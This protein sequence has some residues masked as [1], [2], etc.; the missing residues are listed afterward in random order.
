MCTAISICN[1]LL[2]NLCTDEPVTLPSIYRSRNCKGKAKIITK[3]WWRQVLVQLS[4]K[5]WIHVHRMYSVVHLGPRPFCQ[6]LRQNKKVKFNRLTNW[7]CWQINAR[8]RACFLPT[9]RKLGPS[10]LIYMLMS[11]CDVTGSLQR[12]LLLCWQTARHSLVRSRLLTRGPAG[13]GCTS[14]IS[15]QGLSEPTLVCCSMV[16]HYRFKSWDSMLCLNLLSP[17]LKHGV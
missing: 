9:A 3:P 13:S 11:T 17:K 16:R 4:I 8:L 2:Q 1:S 6:T 5:S 12:Y 10:L 7:C 15:R 14:G